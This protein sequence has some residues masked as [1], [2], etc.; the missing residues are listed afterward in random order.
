M[1][2]KALVSRLRR[3]VAR[4]FVDHYLRDKRCIDCGLG[5]PI[6]LEF[7]HVRGAK[8]F[9]VSYMISKGYSTEVIAEEIKK[10][11]VRCANCHRI[12]TY[13]RRKNLHVSKEKT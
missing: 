12:I 3:Q 5:N 6:C 1:S 2:K 4:R 13:E 10:C 11:E 7:D 8:R 9:A